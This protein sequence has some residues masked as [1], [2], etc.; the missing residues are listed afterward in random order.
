MVKLA[1]EIVCLW[2]ASSVFPSG[3]KYQGAGVRVGTGACC[4]SGAN[5]KVAVSS[6]ALL[7]RGMARAV[8]LRDV[9]KGLE[10]G[11]P[12]ARH[13]PGWWSRCWGWVSAPA[14][15]AGGSWLSRFPPAPG[16]CEPKGGTLQGLE[17]I[18]P[19]RGQTLGWKPGRCGVA[20]WRR[21]SSHSGRR[22]A[23][24]RCVLR[25]ASLVVVVLV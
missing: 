4:V 2:K 11:A 23:V 1:A 14:V 15:V 6:H 21:V 20:R 18:S 25:S 12:A 13:L 24:H 19:F 22:A 3:K 9:P 8:R 5:T 7:P 10:R 16:R 17:S